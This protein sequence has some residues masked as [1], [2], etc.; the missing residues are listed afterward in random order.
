LGVRY[1]AK[2]KWTV[3]ADGLMEKKSVRIGY[4]CIHNLLKI[5]VSRHPTF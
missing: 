1:G 2:F 3:R 5:K 4:K